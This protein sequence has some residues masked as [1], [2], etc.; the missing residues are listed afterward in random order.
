MQ[1]RVIT[2]FC[3]VGLVGFTFFGCK[4]GGDMG[5]AQVPSVSSPAL[6]GAGSDSQPKVATAAGSAIFSGVSGPAPDVLDFGQKLKIDQPSPRTNLNLEYEYDGQFDW[7]LSAILDQSNQRELFGKPIAYVAWRLWDDYAKK[8]LTNWQMIARKLRPW[9]FMAIDLKVVDP[10]TVMRIMTD[11]SRLIILFSID[12]D[13]NQM[14]IT[15]H[16]RV[17]EVCRDAMVVDVTRAENGCH[18]PVLPVCEDFSGRYHDSVESHRSLT[19]QQ[20]ACTSMKIR[21]GTQERTY[22]T[23]FDFHPQSDGTYYRS[24]FLLKT[25]VIE[26]W[27]S[28]TGGEQLS[29]RLVWSLDASKDGTVL[30]EKRNNAQTG[31]AQAAASYDKAKNPNSETLGQEIEGFFEHLWHGSAPAQKDE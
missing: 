31:W 1:F 30:T 8:Y 29:P 20:T 27:T 6:P 10:D 14:P 4:S 24:Y 23:D 28:A 2:S 19:V 5:N 13:I 15:H 11:P 16:L 26:T 21:T 18:K 9:A 12:G 22:L 7:S 17:D 3:F 25:F